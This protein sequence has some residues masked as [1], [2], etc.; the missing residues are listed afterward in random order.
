MVQTLTWEN[1]TETVSCTLLVQWKYN[2]FMIWQSVINPLQHGV[3]NWE[4]QKLVTLEVEI[5]HSVKGQN[6]SGRFTLQFVA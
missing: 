5:I 3:L 4:Q 1:I 6:W 2:A